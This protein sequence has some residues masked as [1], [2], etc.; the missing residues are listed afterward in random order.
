VYAAAGLVATFAVALAL[1][2]TIARRLVTREARAR[3]VELDF[4]S[5]SVR[6]GR[7]LL[8]G[9]RLSLF[10][11][12]GASARASRLEID[13]DGLTPRRIGLEALDVTLVGLDVLDE[14]PRWMNE[15]PADLPLRALDTHVA[16]SERDGAP[17]AIDIAQASLETA[18]E[19]LR[20]RGDGA[21]LWGREAIPLEARMDPSGL[22]VG[23]GRGGLDEAPIR[24]TITTTAGSVTAHASIGRCPARALE[25][26]FQLELPFGSATILG[27]ATLSIAKAAPAAPIEGAVSF[28]LVGFVPPHPTELDGIVFGDRTHVGASLHI[29]SDRTHVDVPELTIAA[30]ALKMSGRAGADLQGER[31]LEARLDGSIAC[32]LLA[33]SVLKARLGRLAADLAG[34]AFGPSLEGVVLVHVEVQ[35]G[36][37]R[38]GSVHVDKNATLRCRLR[39]LPH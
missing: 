30:G 34:A 39:G 5:I 9:V 29:G 7:V 25:E 37:E 21:L 38:L 16:W 26:V 27:D 14:L 18:R 11:V 1:L 13:L 17:R 28:D 24:V 32:R 12:H 35:G 10:S 33:S 23:L 15:H 36:L 20:L 4:E 3:G 2:P 31:R 19:S 22:R 8:D 6:P